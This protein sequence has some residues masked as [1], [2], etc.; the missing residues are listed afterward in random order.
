MSKSFIFFKS[1]FFVSLFIFPFATA[2]QEIEEVVVTAT[3]KAQSTQDIAVSITA[4]TADQLAKDQI[5]DLSDLAEIIPGFET[6]KGI[7]SGSGFVMRG[8]GSYGVGAAVVGS[9]VTSINGHSA[10]NSVMTDLGFMDLERIEV[11]NG[12]QGTLFGRNSVAGVINLITARPTREVE[13]YI[14]YEG[15]SF[16]KETI[17]GAINI[18][19]SDSVAARLAFMTNTRDGM[20]KNPHTGNVMDDRNDQGVRLSVDW[21]INDVTQLKF[22]YS[23]QKSDDNRPQEEA[24]YCKQDQFFGCSPWERGTLN[25]SADSRGIGGGLFNFIAA[26][27]PG[28]ILNSYAASPPS[29]EFGQLSVDREPTHLQK[30]EFSNLELV[31][32][33]NDNLTM[34]AKYSYETRLFQ[35]MNDNDGSVSNAPLIGAGVLLGLPPVVGE[36]CF[37]TG[38]FGFCETVAT[39]RSYDFSDA[40]WESQ[41][42]EINII[43]DYDGAFNFTAGYYT[44]DSRNDNEYR[45]Q[46]TGTQYIG[47]FSIHPYYPTVT[48][49][50]GV[51][52]G[53]KGGVAF[54]QGLL[55]V[56]AGAQDAVTT[57]TMMAMGM[58]PSSAQLLRL[59]AFGEGVTALTMMPDVT[60]PMDLRGTLSD[61]HVRIKSRAIYGEAYFDLNE[62][63]MLTLGIRYDDLTNATTTYSGGILSSGWIAA[64]GYNYK[65]RMEVPGLVDYL[66]QSESAT[67]G[68]IAIQKYLQDDVMVYASY[69]TATKGAGVNAGDTPIPYDKEE[70]AVLDFGLKARLLDGAM[71]LNMNL[72][73]NDNSGMLLATIRDTQS[74]NNNVD[75]E[76]TG[77][78]GQLNV[79]LSETTQ[80]EF[81]WL[82]V[83]SEIT[84]APATINYLNPLNA[85]GVL[86]YL[87]PVDAR[88]TGFQTGAVMNDGSTLYKSAGFSC[89]SP[90]FAPAAN[91]PCPASVGVSS[92]VAGNPLPSVADLSYSLSMTQL[93]PSSNGITSAR[94]SYRYRDPINTDAF[95]TARFDVPEN[96]SWDL[97]VRYTPNNGDWYIGGYAK[98]L[99]DDRVLN[100]IRS[101]SNIQG[102]QLYANFTDPRTYG[103]QFG[104]SF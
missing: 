48:Q 79:F 77:F 83:D 86:Q 68:K 45:V 18:P 85:T 29:F 30:F 8:V 39:D 9:I 36:L 78:E 89:T 11:L 46:T 41:Q 73:R 7:G 66:V 59:K 26:L 10:L 12:P 5:Y 22:T 64:G 34:T 4:V 15:G 33:L 60:V 88:G 84:D 49:L 61:Q 74:F 37:G 72:F 28:T 101:G 70:T 75:A 50:L 65:N 19:L 17:K 63:T 53:N 91:V 31:R 56:V 104:W 76:I 87:G 55:G 98:N 99:E 97:L 71:L 102:G 13:G 35:Q 96:K 32:E 6:S 62:T 58:T 40:S 92:S 42:G 52:L 51:D 25:T 47:D 80:L 16:E 23:G 100:S 43:S 94:L 1:I 14:D 69:A 24:S 3:K 82:A 38:R 21:D 81:S 20:V 2:A 57:Q 54:Y 90:F 27:Y 93:Y 67:N 44:Y 95:A 103:V